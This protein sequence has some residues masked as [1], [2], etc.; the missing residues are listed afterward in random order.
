MWKLISTVF[1]TASQTLSLVGCSDGGRATSRERSI[2]SRGREFAASAQAIVRGGYQLDDIT[3]HVFGVEGVVLDIHSNPITLTSM[4]IKVLR[5]LDT[6]VGYQPYGSAETVIIHFDE[7]RSNFAGLA[8]T[9]GKIVQVYFGQVGVKWVSSS[10]WTGVE[11][12]G[13]TYGRDG[14]PVG[15][16]GDRLFPRATTR[17][18]D[19]AAAD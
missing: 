14:R 8:L 1:L 5:T 3:S 6:A 2:S 12:N 15:P 11:R 18:L 9:S 16:N 19:S 10:A 7:P 13:T 17:A 4:T